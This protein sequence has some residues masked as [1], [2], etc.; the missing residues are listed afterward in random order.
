MKLK[1]RIL[2]LDALR[3]IAALVVI[4][5][6]YTTRYQE[7]FQHKEPMLFSFPIGNFGVQ[8]FFIISG[9]AIYM[10]L[11]NTK[12]LKD[13]AIKRIIRLYPAYIIAVVLT[14]TLTHLYQLQ[15]RMV[16]LIN[17]IVNITMLGGLLGVPYV[18]GVYWSLLV[19]MIFYVLIGILMLIGLLKK[20]EYA[21]IAWLAVCAII[22]VAQLITGGIKGGNLI[23]M[24]AITQFCNLFIAG[25][26]FYKIKQSISKPLHHLIV[27]AC[28]VYQFLFQGISSGLIVA[29]FFLVFYLVV[30]NKLQFI[31][32]NPLTF[33][34]F[35][36]Y[37]LYLVHQNIGYIVINALEKNGFTNQIFILVPITV[38]IVLA[39]LITRF[40]EKP[41]Q[42]FALK[43]YNNVKFRPSVAKP[44]TTENSLAK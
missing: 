6:H 37:A 12:S 3:G 14:F 28:L 38:S 41:V 20:I 16:S 1:E 23:G 26:M 33:L 43:A 4:L 29:L 10:T 30:Y 27:G 13:F 39:Y 24:L 18:D 32:I 35:I 9:F 36:S 2:E 25:I 7:I 17:G 8:L 21:S 19:E 44:A 34:G 22:N 11:S 42:S 40:I 15:G 5:Y 31:A